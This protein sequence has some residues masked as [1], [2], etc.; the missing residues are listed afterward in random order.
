MRVA[1][2]QEPSG[3]FRWTLA[4]SPRDTPRAMSQDD[5]EVVRAAFDAWNRGPEALGDILDSDVDW[6]A[7]E[8]APDDVGPMRGLDAM[9][10]YTRDWFDHFDDLRL[11]PEELI[12]AGDRVVA[13]QRLSGR[14]KRSGIETELRFAVV[15]TVS[16]GK[17]VRGREYMTR[18][19]A[20]EAVRLDE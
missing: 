11:E 10:A 17:I 18:E 12:D 15:Y 1:W 5:V 7:I 4:G 19:P 8:G 6:R 14:A 20:L 3:V 2:K 9:R 13:V 16:G